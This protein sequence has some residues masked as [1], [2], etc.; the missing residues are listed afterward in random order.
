MSKLF[1]V[2]DSIINANEFGHQDTISALNNLDEIYAHAEN[3]GVNINQ[4]EAEKIGKVGL[5]WIN[6]VENGN[7]EWSLYRDEAK[8]ELESDGEPKFLMNPF[9]GSVDTEENWLADMQ[10]W[11]TMDGKTPQEQFDSL[12]EVVKDTNGDWV[13]A[14]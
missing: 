14:E 3:M 4:T 10:E 12:I 11:E 8:Q 5:E 6:K 2:L 9:T 1:N 7:G 13:E